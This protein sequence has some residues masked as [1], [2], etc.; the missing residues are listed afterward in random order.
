MG[1]G[2]RGRGTRGK[3]EKKGKRKRTE[4]NCWFREFTLRKGE[5]RGKGKNNNVREYV[6]MER[7][8]KKGKEGR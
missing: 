6:T 8:S 2:G 5:R 7:K 3:E 1:G 4:I